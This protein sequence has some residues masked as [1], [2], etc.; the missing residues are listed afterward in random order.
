MVLGHREF[1]SFQ[2]HYIVTDAFAPVLGDIFN[3]MRMMNAMQQNSPMNRQR[4]VISTEVP[5]KWLKIGSDGHIDFGRKKEGQKDAERP[6]YVVLRGFELVGLCYDQTLGSVVDVTSEAAR[7]FC[8]TF[9]LYACVVGIDSWQAAGRFD[10]RARGASLR[11][12]DCYVPVPLR[13]GGYIRPIVLLPNRSELPSA[14]YA[15]RGAYFA[16]RSW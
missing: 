2:D 12:C 7:G 8:Q 16:A 3:Y 6:F 4:V 1:G 9:D 11:V 13:A 14:E 15:A 10:R 5:H